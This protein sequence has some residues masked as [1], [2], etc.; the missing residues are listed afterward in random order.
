MKQAVY[1][2]VSANAK[3]HSPGKAVNSS[4]VKLVKMEKNATAVE[5]ATNPLVYVHANKALLVKA[6]SCNVTR[7]VMEMAVVSPRHL[8][9]LCATANRVSEVLVARFKLAAL[10]TMETKAHAME[11][12]IV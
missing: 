9:A 4:P 8:P 10:E 2:M 3:S 12:E 1:T 11:M 7:N 5:H 6:A